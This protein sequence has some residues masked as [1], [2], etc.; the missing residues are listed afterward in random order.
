MIARLRLNRLGLVL[1]TVHLAVV[2]WIYSQHF[3]GSWGGFFLFLIDFPISLLSFVC[4][5]WNQFIFFI[6]VV[7]SLW[8]YSLGLI[9]TAL[10]KRANHAK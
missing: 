9:I 7:G 3:E 5:G 2:Y 6:S 10:I 4:V 8:W 1:L